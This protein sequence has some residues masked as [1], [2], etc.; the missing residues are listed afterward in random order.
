MVKIPFR[1]A[2]FIPVVAIAWWLT[3]HVVS[4]STQFGSRPR[5]PDEVDKD[6]RKIGNELLKA[7]GMKASEIG[8]DIVKG[9]LPLLNKAAVLAGAREGDVGRFGK[10]V[11]DSIDLQKGA[12]RSIF[13][14]VLDLP[15]KVIRSP[16]EQDAKRRDQQGLKRISDGIR[17]TF[18]GVKQQIPFLK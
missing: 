8:D 18:R 17:E 4:F 6:N 10:V 5:S 1:L 3:I 11:Q 15:E 13:G 9:S 7:A 2:R 16:E 14:A 12:V